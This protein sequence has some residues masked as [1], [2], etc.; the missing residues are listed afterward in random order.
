MLTL[1]ELYGSALYILT[2]LIVLRLV[3]NSFI[4]PTTTPI[5]VDHHLQCS[6]LEVLPPAQVQ[7]SGQNI[8]CNHNNLGHIKEEMVK[9]KTYKRLDVDTIKTIRKYRLSKRGERGGQKRHKQGKVDLES[10]ITVNINEDK[11]KL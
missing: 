9:D 1:Q 8:T 11:T 5:M 10:L 2:H 4:E 6:K 3:D 7:N